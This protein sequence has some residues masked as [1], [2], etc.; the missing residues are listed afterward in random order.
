MTHNGDPGYNAEGV[1]G[2]E[3]LFHAAYDTLIA[4]P[5]VDS[6]WLTVEH[7]EPSAMHQTRILAHTRD[8]QYRVTMLVQNLSSDPGQRRSREIT[9]MAQSV[10]GWVSRPK[11]LLHVGYRVQ[12]DPLGEALVWAESTRRNLPL[13]E[14]ERAFM[15]AIGLERQLDETNLH[16][17]ERPNFLAGRYFA[18]HS[19]VALLQNLPEVVMALG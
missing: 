11:G 9:V 15:R 2:A 18:N 19:E 6:T 8:M 14:G 5:A 7:S 10:E 16:F 4:R 17:P 1:G 12:T 13:T 3:A